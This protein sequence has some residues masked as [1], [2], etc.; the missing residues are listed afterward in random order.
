M[1]ASHQHVASQTFSPNTP[2]PAVQALRRAICIGLR[3]WTLRAPPASFGGALHPFSPSFSRFVTDVPEIPGIPGIPGG[4]RGN[5]GIWS[6]AFCWRQNWRQN[7]ILTLLQRSL[8]GKYYDVRND[9]D[10]K[11][12]FARAGGGGGGGGAR[13][14][15][16][17]SSIQ[18]THAPC[19][20]ATAAPTG[21]MKRKKLSLQASRSRGRLCI[22]QPCGLFLRSATRTPARHVPHAAPQARGQGVALFDDWRSYVPS[23]LSV[24]VW[25]AAGIKSNLVLGTCG[26]DARTKNS[27]ALGS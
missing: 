4:N 18:P 24:L 23:T 17:R 9:P 6:R 7:I 14:Q 2:G 27:F 26:P 20:W 12:V 21:S 19:S 13:Q 15:A 11:S 1:S 25:T 5:L 22:S 10:N 16:R 3:T 8:S